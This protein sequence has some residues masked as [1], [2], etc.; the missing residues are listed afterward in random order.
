M[1]ESEGNRGEQWLFLGSGNIENKILILGSRGTL[2]IYF[3]EH[4]SNG[5]K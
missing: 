3:Q 4:K 5:L 2:A 1:S